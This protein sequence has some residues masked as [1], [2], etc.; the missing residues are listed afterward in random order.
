ML[1]IR[2]LEELQENLDKDMAWRLKKIS[3]FRMASKLEGQ[4]KKPFICAGIALL[5]A[6]WEGFIKRSSEC[7]LGYVAGR[8]LRYSELK[9]CFAVFGLKG[10]LETLLEGRKSKS[11]VA[12]FDF[13]SS[14]LNE[15]AKL[16]MSAAI[17]T[18]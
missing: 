11:N 17:N 5:Y 16:Q 15:V 8:G 7:Y 1:K 14:G 13:I 12:A 4:K 10:Q 9:S 2:T 3:T 6:H 18:G